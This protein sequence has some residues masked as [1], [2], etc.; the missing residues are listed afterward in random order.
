MSNAADQ[1]QPSWARLAL[2]RAF[3]IPLHAL[4]EVGILSRLLWEVVLWSIRPPYRIGLWI[5]TCEF[6]GVQS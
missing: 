1:N 4:A 2:E 6:V 3:S 5:A